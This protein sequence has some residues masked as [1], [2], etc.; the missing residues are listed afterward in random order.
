MA[1]QYGEI[2]GLGEGIWM[3]M[4]MEESE[5]L[6]FWSG[7]GYSRRDGWLFMSS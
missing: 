5:D 4:A 7:M 3:V 1:R 6:R 2:F